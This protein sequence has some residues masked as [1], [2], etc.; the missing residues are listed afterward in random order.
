MTDITRA[1]IEQQALFNRM[2]VRIEVPLYGELR[3]GFAER[4]NAG[5]IGHAAGAKVT[6]WSAVD[7]VS[8]A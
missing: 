7:G 5:E 1:V 3:G 6:G 4:G 8:R 2:D